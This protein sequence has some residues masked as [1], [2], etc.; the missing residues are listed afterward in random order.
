LEKHSFF[1]AAQDQH[2]KRTKGF[3]HSKQ[4]RRKAR[5]YYL[6]NAFHKKQSEFDAQLR[7]MQKP[8]PGIRD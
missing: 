5:K 6:P 1:H 8:K 3:S 2:E 4:Q 7:E